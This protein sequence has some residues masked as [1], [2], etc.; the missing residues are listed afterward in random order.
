MYIQLL[1]ITIDNCKPIGREFVGSNKVR[2]TRYIGL[3]KVVMRDISVEKANLDFE[4]EK[5]DCRKQPVECYNE[6]LQG[7]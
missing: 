6:T 7:V 3:R 4:K 2:G 5:E 1:N